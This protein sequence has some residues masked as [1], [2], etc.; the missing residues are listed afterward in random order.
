MNPVGRRLCAV[1]VALLTVSMG[2]PFSAM[3]W[4]S[5][6]TNHDELIN[7]LRQ[8]GI[9]K[10][11]RVYDAMMSV[12]RGSYSK[13]N[14]YM[15][16]P[17]SIGYAVTIS[18]PHMHA[19]AL[20]LLSEHL[21]EGNRALDVG[22]GS[23]YLT[24]CMAL[25]VGAEGRV[26]GIDHIKELVDGSIQNVRNTNK[27]LLDSGRLTLVTGDGRQG[28]APGGP[29]DAIHVGAAADTVPQALLDQLKPGGRLVLPVGPAGGSQMLEQ[30][31]KQLDGTIKKKNLMGVIYVPLTSK[32]K[33][34]AG[35]CQ[36]L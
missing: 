11:S 7:R 29:Y 15:D 34:W 30:H 17:Q 32:D 36:V 5:S 20:E 23:G 8:N 27:E 21:K 13:H 10:S 2:A 4:R 31:D 26:V 3:A 12:D 16:S 25:M 1:S 28:Y 9:I 14:P 22:S 24:V 6:G 35:R 19:H 18:A 33:Q